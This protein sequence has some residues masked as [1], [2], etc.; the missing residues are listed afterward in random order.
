M[1]EIKI[2]LHGTPEAVAAT[3]DLLKAVEQF[4][5]SGDVE[6]LFRFQS[7]VRILS[8]S[9]DRKDRGESVK[10]RRYIDMEIRSE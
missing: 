3:A 8:I 2:R 6:E 4:L 7:Y 10:V 1:P 9:P 5:D